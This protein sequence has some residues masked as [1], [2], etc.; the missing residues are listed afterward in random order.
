M[1][2]DPGV[3]LCDPEI[4]VRNWEEMPT[5]GPYHGHDG[6][7]EWFHDVTDGLAGDLR[8]FDLVELVDA[9]DGRV[10]GIQRIS[11][12][13]WHTGLDLGGTWGAVMTVRDGL[14]VS[15]VGHRRPR[16]AKRA[17]GLG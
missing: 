2:G 16:D 3:E 4:E 11:G 8:V 15:A 6:V 9:G 5:P 7:R 12:R 10:V 17:A 13:A 14:I 1:A